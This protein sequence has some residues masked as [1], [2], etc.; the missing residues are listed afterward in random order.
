LLFKVCTINKK[1]IK[2]YHITDLVS[3]SFPKTTR[4]E[5]MVP[6]LVP[7]H[8]KPRGKDKLY[9]IIM[10]QSFV[11]FLL[12]NPNSEFN[13]FLGAPQAAKKKIWNFFF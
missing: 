1:K 6:I 10:H 7:T 2:K 12:L 4:D 5:F 13:Y 8:L 3:I 9:N 11:F